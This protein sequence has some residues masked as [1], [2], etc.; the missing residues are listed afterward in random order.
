MAFSRTASR[1]D[2]TYLRRRPKV[3]E[4][5][6]P[7]KQ[8]SAPEP[9]RLSLKRPGAP[10]PPE[11]PPVKRVLGRVLLTADV[12]TVT[13]DRRQSAIGSLT[14]EVAGPGAVAAIWELTD[15][16]TGIIDEAEQVR[17][18]PEFG[19]RP[20]VELHRGRIIVGLR[21]V[22]ELRRLLI[23][24]NGFRGNDPQRLLATLHDDSTF[25]SSHVGTGP[26]VAALAIYNVDGE[27]VVRREG[28]GVDSAESLAG[29][30]GF[31]R[32]WLPPVQRS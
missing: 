5:P 13:L 15:G 25:E 17:T 1:A 3:G 6:R 32:T 21:H 24:M 8:E 11:L 20:I 10:K 7:A 14:F 9:A 26:Y 22:K 30:Y 4:T 12:P 16:T 27:L 18:S 23:L 2:I 31:T 28:E 29:A 19:R